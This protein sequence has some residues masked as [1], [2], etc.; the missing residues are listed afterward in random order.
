[1]LSDTILKKAKIIYQIHVL[2][3]NIEPY[4]CYV[5][6]IQPDKNLFVILLFKMFASEI[7][8]Y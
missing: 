5:F 7:L 1:M 2:I 3:S 4:A 6:Q 8:K